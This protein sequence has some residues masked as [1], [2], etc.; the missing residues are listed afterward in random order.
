MN[1]SEIAIINRIT[2]L[3]SRQRDNGNIVKKLR[4][5][6]ALLRGEK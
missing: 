2:L 1:K 5:Q 6:L 4:R 3:E